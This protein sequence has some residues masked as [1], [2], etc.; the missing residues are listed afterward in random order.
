MSLNLTTVLYAWRDLARPGNVKF[1]DHTIP[2][3]PSRHEIDRDTRAYIRKDQGKSKYLWKTGQIEVL[4]IWDATD[5]AVRMRRNYPHASL[6][7]YIANNTSIRLHRLA[8]DF[9]QID[10]DQLISIVNQQLTGSLRLNDF[11][12]HRYQQQAID[13]AVS[14]YNS[15]ANNQDFLLDC[16]MR[17]GK[18]FTSYCIARELGARRILVITGR[19]K[20]KPGW[21][22][23]LD[24]VDFGDWEFID[25]QTQESVRFHDPKTL[26]KSGVQAQVVFASFQGSKN[27]N[28]ASRIQNLINDEIDLV[29]IDEAHAYSSAKALDFVTHTL[30][31]RRRLWVSGTP[32]K[33]YEEGMFDGDTDTYRFTLVDLQRARA[34]VL[35]LQAQGLDVDP[36]LARFTDFPQVQFLVADYPD[37]SLSANAHAIVGDQGLNMKALLGNNQGTTNY[38]QEVRGLLDSLRQCFDA[39]KRGQLLPISAQHVWLAVPAGG[40]D[41]KSMSVAAATTL[42]TEIKAHATMGIYAPLAV[43]GDKE[44]DDVDRHMTLHDRTMTFSCRS[45]NTGTRFPRLDT[46][47][48]LTETTSASEF[49]QTVGRVLQPQAGKDHVTVICYSIEMMVN[50]TNKMVEY[51]ARN[52]SHNHM[53]QEFLDM[54]PIFTTNPNVGVRALDVT[55]LYQQLSSRG[56]ATQ[57]FGDREVLSAQFDALVQANPGF[58]AGIPDVNSDR[59]PRSVQVMSS[60]TAGKNSQQTRMASGG[61]AGK[62]L[63]AETQERVREFLKLTGSIMAA[64]ALYDHH[65]I[66]STQDLLTANPHTVDNELYPGTLSLLQQL[67]SMGALNPGVLDRKISAFHQIEIDRKVTM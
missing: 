24:H 10:P 13:K 38:P 67:V 55:E 9:Y 16:V 14:Y 36:G 42:E 25:S 3:Q 1:G 26:D 41:S 29:I 47:V 40:D 2:G 12:P 44:Q 53:I 64:S 48:F 33:A 54:M 52:T 43:K 45:L 50:M 11:A 49:W 6:D 21:R 19:P 32:F 61:A 8:D 4:K 18:C 5:Y 15:S 35:D 63:L 59:A 46:V 30:R 37:F 39:K 56:S 23:D 34:E 31:A 7:E 65:V 60:G 57:A 22:D 27:K 66:T 58:F 20:V 62:N 17:F 28:I 51:S